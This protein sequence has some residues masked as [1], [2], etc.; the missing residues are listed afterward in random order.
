MAESFPDLSG[1]E[2]TRDTLHRYAKL[3]GAVRRTCTE[4][5]PLW[6]HISL[7]PAAA[8]LATGELAAPGGGGR[9]SLT[10]DL[11]R[12]QLRLAAPG[13]ERSLP[14]DGGL[15]ATE[16]GCRALAHLAELGA[17]VEVDEE[18]FGDGSACAYDRALAGRYLTALARAE[19]CF[20]EL[21]DALPGD[22]GPIQLWPHNFDLAFEWFGDRRVADEDDDGRPVESRT[23]VGFGFSPGDASHPEPYFYATPWPFEAE[24]TI[25][26]LPPGAEW[27]TE[28]WEGG[29]LPYA[30][31]RRGG[32]EVVRRF[33]RT[34]WETAAP[35][36]GG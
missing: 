17:E 24:F 31:A 23:Q 4:P 35:A 29:L 26:P 9:L 10:L 5:H 22:P 25:A 12:H 11:E 13:G 15:T 20:A 34:V 14:L 21:R 16:L 18:H 1:W 33:L 3:L 8:G 27:R 32:E 19:A 6:W 30:S 7:R 2:P 36:L 28:G